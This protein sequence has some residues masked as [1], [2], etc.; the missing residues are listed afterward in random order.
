[1]IHNSTGVQS[2]RNAKMTK[3]NAEMCTMYNKILFQMKNNTLENK[4]RMKVAGAK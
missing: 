1:M 2:I 3:T 4:Q